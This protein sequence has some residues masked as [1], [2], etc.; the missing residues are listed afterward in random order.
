MP[1]KTFVPLILFSFFLAFLFLQDQQQHQK[2]GKD[3]FQFVYFRE[4][5][6]I[7]LSKTEIQT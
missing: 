6:D 2:T 1:Q 3:K 7:C 5:I 4:G